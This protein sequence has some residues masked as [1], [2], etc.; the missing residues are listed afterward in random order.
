[1][2]ISSNEQIYELRKKIFESADIAVMNLRE[3]MEQVSP[4]GLL[5]L[6]KFDKTGV[7]PVDGTKLNLIEQLN[8]LFSD[9]VALEAV[10]DLLK[11]YPGKEFEI[12]L[13]T[14]AGFDVESTDGEVVC[15]C[16]AVTTAGSNGKLKKDAE[17]LLLKAPTKMK[18]IYFY[19]Q[20]DKEETLNRLYGRFPEITFRRISDF[21]DT[22]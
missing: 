7:D 15:E 1:M 20:N 9:L 21:L 3:T 12:H 6:M 10:N 17:K 5:F 13:G 2:R 11:R 16:F 22:K 14:E 4:I 8:Q 18:Y 19:S